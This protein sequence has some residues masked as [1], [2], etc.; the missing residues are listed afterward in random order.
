MQQVLLYMYRCLIVDSYDCMS[1]AENHLGDVIFIAYRL[2]FHIRIHIFLF[3]CGCGQVH[4]LTYLH[5]VPV[6][7]PAGAQS[8]FHPDCAIE[9]GE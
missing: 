4:V 5:T 9:N 2:V 7:G 6:Y 8:H 3:F 1:N